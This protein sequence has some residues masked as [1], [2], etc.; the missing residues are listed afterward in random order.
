MIGNILKD[1]KVLVKYVLYNHSILVTE[2]DAHTES[3]YNSQLA[4]WLTIN[5]FSSKSDWL[6][7]Y[8]VHGTCYNKKWDPFNTHSLEIK[9]TLVV[10]IIFEIDRLCD[11]TDITI[12]GGQVLAF[13]FNVTPKEQQR[14]IVIHIQVF[15]SIYLYCLA[16]FIIYTIQ[17]VGRDVE[18]KLVFWLVLN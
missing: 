17:C 7:D 5:R 15:N 14:V 1:W 10:S 9:I 8:Q 4:T 12:L 16:T 18:M 6:S 11:S 2:L 3:N 13:L